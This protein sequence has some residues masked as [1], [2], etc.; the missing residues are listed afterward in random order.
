MKFGK[1]LGTLLATGSCISVSAQHQPPNIVFILADD[2]GWTDLSCMGSDF[3]ETPH[4]DTL[5]S[6][7]MLFT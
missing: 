2:L 3:Y 7:G 4:I 6:N 1:L 5:R